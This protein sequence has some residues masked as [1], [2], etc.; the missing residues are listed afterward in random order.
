MADLVES[1]LRTQGCVG[2]GMAQVPA[3]SGFIQVPGGIEMFG[4]FTGS[5]GFR[6]RATTSGPAMYTMPASD[7]QD[8]CAVLTTD[9]AQNLSWATGPTVGEIFFCFGDGTSAL[10]ANATVLLPLRFSAQIVGWSLAG[11][12]AGTAVVDVRAV[13][14]AGHPPTS[15]HSIVAAATPTVTSASLASG[16]TSTWTAT[17][18][19]D[20]HTLAAVLQSTATFQQLTLGLKITR[21]T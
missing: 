17:A 16:S 5:T 7:S 2:V 19:S 21:C 10:A 6:P 20:A 18:L 12:R 13:S 14:S 1:W 9:G 8:G 3:A 11:D 4:S 15:A